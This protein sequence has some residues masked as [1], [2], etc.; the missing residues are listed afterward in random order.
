VKQA[1]PLK[2]NF[3]GAAAL[4]AIAYTRNVFQALQQLCITP[5]RLSNKALIFKFQSAFVD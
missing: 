3:W 2:N 4:F 5:L 1:D